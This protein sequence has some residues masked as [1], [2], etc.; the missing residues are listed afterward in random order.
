MRKTVFTLTGC[1]LLT[2]LAPDAQGQIVYHDI[3]PDKVVSFADYELNVSCSVDSCHL[4]PTQNLNISL[5][6]GGGY[7][8]WQAD[9]QVMV[10][11]QGRAMALNMLD[12]IAGT[13]S[14]AGQALLANGTG[15]WVTVTNKYL[16]VRIRRAGQWHYGWVRMD[17]GA[18]GT[19]GVVKDFAY[20]SQPNAPLNAGQVVITSVDDIRSGGED[21][22]FLSGRKLK[23]RSDGRVEAEVI[24]MD[25]RRVASGS[26]DHN[27]PLD[28]SAIA[29]GVYVVRLRSGGE[30]YNTR[31]SVQ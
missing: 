25:G 19:Y 26:I 15:N 24:S 11:A 31:I 27:A 13:W 4:Y 7:V 23:M 1:L 14:S 29:P 12:Q 17:I 8:Y 2:V 16:G 9:G 6:T 18:N 3:N 22:I 5:Q 28:L 10:D 20:N 21:M 30:H